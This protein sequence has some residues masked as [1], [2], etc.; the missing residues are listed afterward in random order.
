MLLN[1]GAL[2]KARVMKVETARLA[3]GD[4]NPPGVAEPS[5][6]VGAG[7]RALI[8][9]A[10]IIPPGMIGGGGSAGTPFWIDQKRRGAVVFMG[11]GDVR[12]PG[13]LAVS[14]AAVRRHR[15]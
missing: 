8:C 12:R 11:A 2:G 15:G 14:E 6:G 13:A 4:I 9:G 1:E 10:P 5:E 7:T 3:T